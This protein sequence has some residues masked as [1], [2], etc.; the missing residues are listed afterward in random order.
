LFFIN[1]IQSAV[2]V[3]GYIIPK[4]A[5]IVANMLSMHK[6]PELYPE[7]HS[8]K[9]ERFMSNLKTMQS[10]ANGRYEERDHFNFGF[11]R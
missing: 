4:G 11:G 7:P 10:A 1:N 8:F 2:E 6:Q 9:P 5:S 3:D